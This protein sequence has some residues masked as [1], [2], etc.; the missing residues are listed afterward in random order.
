MAPPPVLQTSQYNFP[1]ALFP[2]HDDVICHI[3]AGQTRFACSQTYCMPSSAISTQAQAIGHKWWK[4]SPFKSA[5]LLTLILW[6]PDSS[7]DCLDEMLAFSTAVF[8]ER[9]SY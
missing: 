7:A 3:S 6:L 1:P 4:R 2:W 5:K 9:A 8:L